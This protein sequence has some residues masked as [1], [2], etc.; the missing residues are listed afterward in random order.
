MMVDGYQNDMVFDDDE[1]RHQTESDQ[2]VSV[3]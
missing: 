1:E 3:L 2:N